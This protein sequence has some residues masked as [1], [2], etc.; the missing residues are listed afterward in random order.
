MAPL[1]FIIAGAAHMK[2]G[3]ATDM[4]MTAMTMIITTA[5]I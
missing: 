1:I 4:S 5:M 2:A 3:M